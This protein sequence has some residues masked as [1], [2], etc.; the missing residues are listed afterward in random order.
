VSKPDKQ[1][2]RAAFERAAETYDAAAVVQREVCGRLLDFSDRHPVTRSARRVVDAGCGTGY[3]LGLLHARFLDAEIIAMDF[4]PGMLLRM[5]VRDG[6]GCIRLCADIEQLPLASESV[7]VL[8]SSLML[9]W[10]DS[11]RSLTEIARVLRPGGRAWIATLGPRTLWELREAFSDIDDA[12]HVI[13]FESPEQ[14]T[15]RAASAGL[16]VAGHEVDTVFALAPDLGGLLRDIKA[17]GAHQVGPTRRHG[18][19][20]KGVWRT[21]VGHYERHRR[22]DGLLPASYDATL[23]SLGKPG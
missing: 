5:P 21:L 22:V 20:G 2:V 10:C 12:Q 14:L 9:Q 6:Y 18:L 4:A 1:S 19:F 7:D 17:I 11:Q 23:L 16:E 3:A 13:D 15:A 8:W